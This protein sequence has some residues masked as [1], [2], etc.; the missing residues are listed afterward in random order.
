MV[1]GSNGSVAA[2]AE[3]TEGI[4]EDDLAFWVKGEVRLDSGIYFL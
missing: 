4:S 3:E 1:I 2:A